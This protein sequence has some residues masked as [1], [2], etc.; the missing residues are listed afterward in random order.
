MQ[1][2]TARFEDDEDD[3][4]TMPQHVIIETPGG[5]LD[6]TENEGRDLFDALRALFTVYPTFEYEDGGNTLIATYADG[7]QTREERDEWGGWDYIDDDGKV[8]EDREAVEA[9]TEKHK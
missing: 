3:A 1:D 8:I 2:V 9:E 7:Y 6:L 4:D 5:K